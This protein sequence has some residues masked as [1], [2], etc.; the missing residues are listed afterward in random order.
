MSNNTRP[1][2][3]DIREAYLEDI[4]DAYWEDVNVYE[5]QREDF[6]YWKEQDEKENQESKETK[7]N[8]EWFVTSDGRDVS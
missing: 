5:R 1:T 2:L 7:E 3:E 8:R 6:D 4:R